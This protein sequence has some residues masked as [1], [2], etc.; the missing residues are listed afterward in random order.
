MFLR[1]H[2]KLKESQFLQPVQLINDSSQAVNQSV[3]LRGGARFVSFC[4]QYNLA[5]LFYLMATWRVRTQK[6]F[7]S[8]LSYVFRHKDAFFVNG[9]IHHFFPNPFP[10]QTV[11]PDCLILSR[12]SGCS[13]WNFIASSLLLSFTCIYF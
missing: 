9:R 12:T 6:R 3:E 1:Y 8:N 11:I 4:L 2:A 7:L 10:R 13:H 5:W